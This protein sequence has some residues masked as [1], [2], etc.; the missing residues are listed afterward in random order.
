[1]V[2]RRG[3]GQDR[4]WRGQASLVFQ[5][6]FC[7]LLALWGTGA[8]STP[9]PRKFVWEHVQVR[10]KSTVPASCPPTHGARRWSP[11]R[12]AGHLC[13]RSPHPGAAAG[14]PLLAPGQMGLRALG[15]GPPAATLCLPALP[16]SH[17]GV[18]PRARTAN[19][20]YRRECKGR[21]GLLD[22]ALTRQAL[23]RRAYRL[24]VSTPSPPAE[25]GRFRQI[26]GRFR[27]MFFPH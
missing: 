10:V 24:V 3:G 1:M 6:L 21:V 19:I 16:S 18:F 2:L 20:R 25:P 7:G 13:S 11:A 27:V 15:S 12:E 14:S 5:L 8:G 22:L 23:C 26:R 4:A 17:S 9:Q